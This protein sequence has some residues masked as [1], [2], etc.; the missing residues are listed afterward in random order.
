M[1]RPKITT[2]DEAMDELKRFYKAGSDAEL[3][4]KLNT[5]RQVISSWRKFQRIPRRYAGRF[6]HLTNGY[7]PITVMLGVKNQVEI[8]QQMIDEQDEF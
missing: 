8:T 6:H 4:R 1:S 5:S 7:L 2:F 3:A